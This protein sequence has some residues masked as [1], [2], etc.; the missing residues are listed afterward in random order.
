MFVFEDITILDQTT[1]SGVLKEVTEDDLSMA[2]KAVDPAVSSF[3]WSCIKES[4]A[5]KIR[6]RMKELGAVRLIDVDAA[7]QRIVALIRRLEE[8]GRIVVGRAGETVA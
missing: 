7:Q 8:E 5:T 6:T 3:I 4:E 1:A 2:L